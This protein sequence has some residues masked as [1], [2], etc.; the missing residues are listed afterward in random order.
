MIRQIMECAGSAPY[1]FHEHNIFFLM[2][3]S[4]IFSTQI[5][6][7]EGG[8]VDSDDEEEEQEQI[9]EGKAEVVALLEARL[10]D[11]RRC[12]RC[13]RISEKQ[14]TEEQ[15]EEHGYKLW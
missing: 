9:K 15:P 3:A 13:E 2:A 11:L 4:S 1:C 7:A 6:R 10:S 5:F 14:E 12:L 8:D